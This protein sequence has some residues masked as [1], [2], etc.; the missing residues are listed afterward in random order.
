MS[1]FL[2]TIHELAL[3][4]MDVLQTDRDAV[5]CITGDTGEGKSSFSWQLSMELMKL[6]GVTYNPVKN[7]VFDKEEFGEACDNFPEFSSVDADE[8]VGIFYARDY[9]DEEQIAILKKADR[10]RYRH[11]VIKCLIPSLFHIDSHIRNARVRIWIY[12]DSRVGRG[13]D[14]YAHAYVFE[15]EKNPF[16]ADPWNM[17]KNRELFTRGKIDKSP[18]YMGE[19][20]FYD[21]KPEEYKIY[22]QVKDLKRRIAESKEWKSAVQKKRRH[23]ST[24]G[25]KM[26]K[27]IGS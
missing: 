27:R 20:V 7:M 25:E 12:I 10:I 2:T 6:T 9:H 3:F 15:K 1:Q 14:G 26:D 8:A 16:N 24:T 23:G 5:L 11:L 22:L 19:I 17:N 4:I 21:F 18:N 13:E